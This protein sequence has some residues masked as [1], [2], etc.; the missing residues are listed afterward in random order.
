VLQLSVLGALPHFGTEGEKQAAGRLVMLAPRSPAA[1]AI[2]TLRTALHFGFAGSEDLRAI[3]ITSPTPGDGKSTIASNL[4]IAMAQADQRVLLI[5]ADLRKPIQHLIHEV[6]ADRG[7]GS[8]LTDR[9]PV[10][11]AI[12]PNVMHNLD[13]LPCG[14]LPAN[15]VE[16]LNN[17][18]FADMLDK[19]RERYDRI[20]IDAPPVVP[21]ADARVIA[22]LADATLLVIRAEQSTRRLSLAARNE[23]WRVRATRIGVVV[24]GVPMRQHGYGYGYGYGYGHYGHVSYQ[25]GDGVS[26]NGHGRKRPALLSRKSEQ[27]I[28]SGTGSA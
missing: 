1:E 12:I 14:P 8:V 11:E 21:L 25:E 16:L 9:R 26:E 20:I 18:F 4:A 5:D 10:A 23:L 22:A 19:L 2:R 7:L 6:P 24:N 28:S 27:T 3:V 13:L 15:P 17:E